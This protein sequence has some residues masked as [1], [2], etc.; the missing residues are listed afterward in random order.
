MAFTDFVQI[1]PSTHDNSESGTVAQKLN[2]VV[3][4]EGTDLKINLSLDGQNFIRWNSETSQMEFYLNSVLEGHLDGTG[5][6]AD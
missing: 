6:A 2:Q 3:Q 4:V 5:F 1:N